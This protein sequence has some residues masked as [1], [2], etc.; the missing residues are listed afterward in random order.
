IADVAQRTAAYG[1]PGF[2]VDGN[3][4]AAVYRMVAP[5]VELARGGGGPTLIE[6]KT[7]KWLGHYVGDPGASRPGEEVAEWK[8]NDPLPRFEAYLL[9]EGVCGAERIERAR[10]A[11][12]EEMEAA[13]EFGRRSPAPRPEDALEDMPA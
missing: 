11:V 13:I 3:D 4:P 1:F 12:E 9:Q 5:A 8:S 7:Y 10:A 2:S 6:C